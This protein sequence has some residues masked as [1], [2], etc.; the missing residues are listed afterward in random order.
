MHLALFLLAMAALAYSLFRFGKAI[1]RLLGVIRLGQ[2]DTTR[3]DNRGRRWKHMAVETLGHTRLLQLN[4]VGI[5]HWFVLTP[6]G[7]AGCSIR[8]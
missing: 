7:F 4:H 5:A 1:K 3:S 8:S 6:W 2:K